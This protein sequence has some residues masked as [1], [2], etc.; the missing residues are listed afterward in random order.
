MA[1]EVIQAI[2]APMSA[3]PE[4]LKAIIGE[5]EYK[6]F[7]AEKA[8]QF[9][10]CIKYVQA[11]ESRFVELDGAA[12]GDSGFKA[13]FGTLNSA[14]KA[15]ESALIPFQS[16]WGMMETA[17]TARGMTPFREALGEKVHTLKDQ[18]CALVSLDRPVSETRV[19]I[20]EQVGSFQD[21]LDEALNDV[22]Q[23]T[24]SD[25]PSKPKFTDRLKSL[26]FGGPDTPNSRDHARKGDGNMTPEEIK[27]LTETVA[28]E[29]AKATVN[30]MVTKAEQEEA[31]KADVE[32]VAAEKAEKEELKTKI[33]DILEYI[34]AQKAEKEAQTAAETPEARAAAEKAEREAA[35]TEM[36]ELKEKLDKLTEKMDAMNRTPGGRTETEVTTGFAKKVPGEAIKYDPAN[37]YATF[38]TIGVP[39]G[40]A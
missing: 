21:W 34:S 40:R 6:K 20:M 5:D 24:K 28:S 25:P 4:Q 10:D 8:E 22:E 36:K 32:A 19:L 11:D 14:E 17:S 37:P 15:D 18:V 33:N 7:T 23:A 26:L 9:E 27:E 13:V 1:G 3:D 12:L 39:Q 2:I 16:K 38:D 29:A 35:E 30:E 31:A